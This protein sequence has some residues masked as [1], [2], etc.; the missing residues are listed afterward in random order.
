MLIAGDVL[1]QETLLSGAEEI[2]LAHRIEAGV[3]ARDA[4]LSR[5]RPDAAVSELLELEEL[6]ELAR[7]RYI[8]ANLRLV[9]KLASEAALRTRLPESDLFQEG[10]LGLI[11]A[12][13]RFDCR[14]GFRFSTYASIWI[15][16]YVGNATANLLGAMNLPAG[17][18][19]Q[20]RALRGAEAQLAQSLGR[21][22]SLG[23]LAAALGRSQRW[24][25]ELLAHEIPQTLDGLDLE[26]VGAL[27]GPDGYAAVEDQDR[28]G[29]ELLAHL[30]GLERQVVGLRFGFADG[31]AHSYPDIARML[32]TSLSRI[33][34]AEQGALE[35]LRSVCPQSA[36]V[37]L[38][39]AR[40]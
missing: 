3:L 15:R 10:C 30:Q 36:R 31:E 33:R 20:L 38:E 2:E 7:Q 34:R 32:S 4:R 25:A 22:P 21:A 1:A 13:E 29:V 6:G 14:R 26:R 37:H 28:P 9:A 18:A 39:A 27:A 19:A 23:E 11:A 40:W 5:T 35:R 12:V 24:S 8:R 16:A 17:R